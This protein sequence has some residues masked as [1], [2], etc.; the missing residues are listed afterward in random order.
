[1]GASLILSLHRRLHAEAAVCSPATTLLEWLFPP[2]WWRRGGRRLG[3]WLFLCSV[4][5]EGYFWW[6]ASWATSAA[7]RFRVAGSPSGAR[8]PSSRW[9][10]YWAFNDSYVHRFIRC[11]S[12]CKAWFQKTRCGF[13]WSFFVELETGF[14]LL[15]RR[16][17]WEIR[18]WLWLL[19]VRIAGS[20][21][22]QW[23]SPGK[24]F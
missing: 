13:V 15:A 17:W 11:A 18:R 3:W 23:G 7:G 10:I 14:K 6:L 24:S 21:C 19:A 2:F 16:P 1:M 4:S 12:T 9:M 22:Q 8:S 20:G 5:E